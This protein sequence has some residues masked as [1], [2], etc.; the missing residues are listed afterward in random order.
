MG[1][2][3]K[4]VGLDVQK[5]TIAISQRVK[6]TKRRGWRHS[7]KIATPSAPSLFIR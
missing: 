2:G 3:S 4:Y 5:E 7:Q 1:D 6:A